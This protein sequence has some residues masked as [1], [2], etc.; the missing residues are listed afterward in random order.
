MPAEAGRVFEVIRGLQ[1]F[2]G[3]LNLLGSNAVNPGLA[4]TCIAVV[5]R[6]WIAYLYIGASSSWLRVW[7]KPLRWEL[8]VLCDATGLIGV[9]L[10]AQEEPAK[11]GIG[12]A[13]LQ[14]VLVKYKEHPSYT[15]LV[16]PPENKEDQYV[17]KVVELRETDYRTLEIVGKNNDHRRLTVTLDEATFRPDCQLQV[18]VKPLGWV[19]FVN[20]V[21]SFLDTTELSGA[22]PTR[23]VELPDGELGISGLSLSPDGS[24]LAFSTSSLQDGQSDPC[25]LDEKANSE[26]GLQNGNLRAVRVTGGGLQHITTEDFY[27]FDPTFSSDGQHLIFS[28]NRRR[29]QSSDIL[30]ISADGRS[31]IADIY[32]NRRGERAV[33]PSMGDDGTIAFALYPTNWT[34]LKDIQ[35]WTVGGKNEF[36]TQV[37]KGMHPRI[38]PDGSRIVYIGIDGN[39]WAVG[40][41]GR[42]ATQLTFD[43]ANIL[44]R[45]K[46]NLSGLE[47][48]DFRALSLTGQLLQYYEHYS[49][50][51]WSPDGTRIVYA[52]MEANDPTGRPNHDIWIMNRDGSGVQQLTTNGSV[53]R[54]PVI[55]PG[56]NYIYFNSNRGLRWAIWRIPTP[57]A[58]V[59]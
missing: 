25:D 23:V 30:R 33:A 26:I 15:T 6:I 4:L 19:G 16:A 9:V 44:E 56:Q 37:A 43:A 32:T 1:P 20:R 49:N 59:S 2:R 55:S 58:D 35:I 36:P 31:G 53:D 14:K 29:P 18:V 51:S 17:E 52:S 54:F 21:R 28:S 47:L 7:L 41:D 3:V 42:A 24:R 11:D 39:V 12:T 8:L 48:A 22:V 45:Y 38:S 34:S 50:P 10:D 46:D 5:V 40:S 13:K 27:D 57:F